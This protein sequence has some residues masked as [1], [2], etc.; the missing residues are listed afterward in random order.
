MVSQSIEVHH[1][2]FKFEYD[3]NANRKVI[4]NLP[5]L[6]CTRGVVPLLRGNENSL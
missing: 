1:P 5:R 2:K 4:N 6:L 3:E